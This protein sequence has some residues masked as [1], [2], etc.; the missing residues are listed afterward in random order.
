MTYEIIDNMRLYKTYFHEKLK[1][2][3]NSL[4]DDTLLIKKGM[5]NFGVMEKVKFIKLLQKRHSNGKLNKELYELIPTNRRRAAYFD[6]DK[7][8]KIDGL[9][10]LIKE[11]QK[12]FGENVRIALSGSA[13]RKKRFKNGKLEV[14]DEITYSYHLV[15]P[16]IVFK[17]KY[18][19]E[20]TGLKMIVFSLLSLTP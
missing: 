7:G 18:D 14:A 4:T 11:I 1:P 2:A 3:E 15:L 17:D 6:F 5:Y 8:T 10:Q 13:G 16:D 9:Y 12:M 20:T 19:M